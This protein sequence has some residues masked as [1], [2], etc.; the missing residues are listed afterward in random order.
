MSGAKKITTV[1]HVG[2]RLVGALK[3]KIADYSSGQARGGIRG[4][5]KCNVQARPK[6]HFTTEPNTNTQTQIHKYTNTNTQP[7]KRWD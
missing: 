2:K 4:R 3:Y 1:C 5:G 6:M 7:G